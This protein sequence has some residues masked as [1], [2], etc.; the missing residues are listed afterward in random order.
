VITYNKLVRDGIPEII[1]RSGRKVKTKTVA[2][3]ELMSALS[4]KLLEECSEFR[5]SQSVEELGDILE[6]LYALASNL[7]CSRVE[8]EKI[9]EQKALANGAFKDGFFLIEAEAKEESGGA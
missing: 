8:L 5:E 6:V 3:D 2:G 7:N 9:R 1:Q 4:A